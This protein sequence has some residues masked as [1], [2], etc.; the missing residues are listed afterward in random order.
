[1]DP[2]LH[3]PTMVK[4]R[5]DE[6]LRQ[7]AQSRMLSQAFKD[8][9]PKPAQEHK[10]LVSIGRTL[11]ALGYSLQAQASQQSGTPIG[12]QSRSSSEGCA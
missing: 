10:F 4:Q 11:V 5:Q 8:A 2:F 6:L 7:A 3:L 9:S 1:M 12:L